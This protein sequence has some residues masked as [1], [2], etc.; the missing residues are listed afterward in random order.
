M[1][2]RKHQ[3]YT[4]TRWRVK[5]GNEEDFVAAWQ[6][7]AAYFSSLPQPPGQGILLQCIDASDLFYSFGPWLD[8]N[9]VR[10]MR[11]DPGAQA[12]FDRLAHLCDETSPGAYRVVATSK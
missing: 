9:A 2:A 3:P 4:L 1:A 11:A 12:A 8:L 7:L 5:P 6:E 10:S